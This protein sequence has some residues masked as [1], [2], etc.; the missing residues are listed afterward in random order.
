MLTVLLS[1]NTVINILCDDNAVV[2]ICVQQK[3]IQQ[4]ICDNRMLTQI[5]FNKKLL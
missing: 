5:V 1:H 2:K 3:L 4:K